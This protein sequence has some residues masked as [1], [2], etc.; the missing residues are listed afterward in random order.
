[1][2]FFVSE[3]TIKDKLSRNTANSREYHS[4]FAAANVLPTEKKFLD[5]GCAN[6]FVKTAN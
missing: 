3:I 4:Q 6:S 5:F 1:L 2:L